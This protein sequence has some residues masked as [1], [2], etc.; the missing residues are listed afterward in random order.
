M[1]GESYGTTRI[2]K[3][4]ETQKQ[5]SFDGVVLVSAVAGNSP[6][7]AMTYARNIP[8]MAVATSFSGPG[9]PPV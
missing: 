4:L 9:V 7:L 6:I 5:L 1:M 3:I 8:S 2:A